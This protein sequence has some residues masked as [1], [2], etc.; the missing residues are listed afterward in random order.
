MALLAEMARVRTVLLTAFL[1]A[2]AA[3]SAQPI[4]PPS[5][6]DLTSTGVS[7]FVFTE[8]GEPTMEVYVVGAARTGIYQVGT[9]TSL[10]KLLA[11]AGGVNEESLETDKIIVTASVEV[12]RRQ[13]DE[14]QL[15]YA[16]DPN[17]LLVEPGRHP[18]LQSGDLVVLNVET[19]RLPDR[20][21]L[22]DVLDVTA[23]VASLVSVVLLISR[24][25]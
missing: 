7:Y 17:Q 3:A 4:L 9:G 25:L 2:G 20:I 11:L 1:V 24:R 18:V 8:R 12:R 15:L 22:R 13:G 16:A 14:M 19:E 10:V 21:T 6:A 5:A 23:R